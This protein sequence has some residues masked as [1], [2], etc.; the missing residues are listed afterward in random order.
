[1][2]L[3]RR[4]LAFAGRCLLPRA[5]CHLNNNLVLAAVCLL[6]NLGRVWVAIPIGERVS[7]SESWVRAPSSPCA[8]PASPEGIEGGGPVDRV[9]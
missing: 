6:C 7:G 5:R 1:M 3:V 4:L 2:V 9:A 8:G